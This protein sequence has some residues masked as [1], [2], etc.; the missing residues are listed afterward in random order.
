MT[1][2]ADPGI[3]TE[4]GLCCAGAVFDYGALGAEEFEPA[5]AN[6][7]DAVEADGAYGFHLPCPQLHGACCKVYDQRPQT[8]RD[9]RCQTLRA[10]EAG[11][12][13]RSEAIERIQRAQTAMVE[14]WQHLPEGTSVVDARRWRREGAQSGGMPS[15]QASPLVMVALGMLDLVL[16]KHFRRVDQR[17]VMPRE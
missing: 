6:G 4:C 5:R 14:L 17:Q 1:D 15:P 16:D 11:D 8:C 12:I 7:L 13:T 2:T 9:Y 3:C 10:L